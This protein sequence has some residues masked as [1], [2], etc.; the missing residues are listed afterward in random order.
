MRNLIL[1]ELVS[2]LKS[3]TKIEKREDI[4]KIQIVE[5]WI[6]DNE[7]CIVVEING[8]NLEMSYIDNTGFI[9]FYEESDKAFQE[10]KCNILYHTLMWIEEHLEDMEDLNEDPNLFTKDLLQIKEIIEFRDEVE[11]KV[12]VNQF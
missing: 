10:L 9:T 1:D 3:L 12:K 5:E 4:I 11:L 6:D 2:D 8:I 7:L